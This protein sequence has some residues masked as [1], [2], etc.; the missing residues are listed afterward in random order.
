M[1]INVTFNTFHSIRTLSI[2][3]AKHA[4]QHNNNKKT[5][6]ENAYQKLLPLEGIAAE[7]I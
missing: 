5:M 1:M 2:A 4:N 7:T 6:K 3:I